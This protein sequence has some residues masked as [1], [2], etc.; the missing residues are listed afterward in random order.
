MGGSR[1]VYNPQEHQLK[2]SIT[3]GEPALGDVMR[4]V[5]KHVVFAVEA[6]RHC[7]PIALEQARQAH[8]KNSGKGSYQGLVEN[9]ERFY[10][11]SPK[12]AMKMDS[13]RQG[14]GTFSDIADLGQNF[15]S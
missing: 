2:Q 7:F 4:N 1:R 13:Q 10:P 3:P 8:L 11:D 5:A 12:E 6:F 9:G 14:L 15:G